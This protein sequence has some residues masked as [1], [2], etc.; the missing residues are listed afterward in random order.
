MVVPVGLH[1]SKMSHRTRPL[2]GAGASM[3]A[4]AH[5]A[6]GTCVDSDHSV[7][8]GSGSLLASRRPPIWPDILG[9]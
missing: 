7:H 5:S 9:M 3:V 6:V 1:V 2:N 8:L 4:C